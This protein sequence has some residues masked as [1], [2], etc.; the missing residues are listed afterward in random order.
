[1]AKMAEDMARVAGGIRTDHKRRSELA[2]EIKVATQNRRSDV[3]SFLKSLKT[4]RSKATRERMAEASKMMRARHKEVEAWLKGLTAARGKAGSEH[5]KEAMAMNKE[6]QSN[7]KALMNEF[8]HEDM[9]RRK[10]FH[11]AA[12]AFMKNLTS[13]VA[14]LL[15]GFDK[16]NRDRA[17]AVRERFAIYAADRRDAMAVW[18]GSHKGPLHATHRPAH[19]HAEPSSPAGSPGEPHFP[20][21]PMGTANPSSR[22]D[23]FVNMGHSSSKEPHKGGSK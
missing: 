5:Q 11:E 23:S 14:A 17:M 18:C 13:G 9:A 4:A 1:M 22:R 16:L 7:V 19:G 21:Q 8:H 12:A 20:T 3:D 6:R 15:D 10:H 2:M